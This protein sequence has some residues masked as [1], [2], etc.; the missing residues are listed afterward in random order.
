MPFEEL[1]HFCLHCI[2]MC[3]ELFIDFLIILQVTAVCFM[4]SPMSFLILV[5]C[6]H[7]HTDTHTHAYIHSLV[8]DFSIL[9]IFFPE[10]QHFYR[11][12][13][14]FS[15]FKFFAIYLILKGILS[16]QNNSGMTSLFYLHLEKMLCPFLLASLASNDAWAS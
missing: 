16:I 11:C 12:L 7:T 2:F 5:I 14:C 9:L 8:R 10:N 3:I 13:C 4:I 15:L 6:V 1:I